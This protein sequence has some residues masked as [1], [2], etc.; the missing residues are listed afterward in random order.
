MKGGPTLPEAVGVVGRLHSQAE[1]ARQA[2]DPVEQLLVTRMGIDGRREGRHVSSKS[3]R[4]EEVLGR[5]LD[6]LA[7]LE[8]VIT[9]GSSGLSP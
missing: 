3:L 4:Q 2:T 8:V 9:A 6:F 5:R 1:S 7:G